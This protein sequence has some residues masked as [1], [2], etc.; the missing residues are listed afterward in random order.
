M[1]AAIAHELNQPLTATISFARACQA[2]LDGPSRDP[3]TDRE[4]RGL[5]DQA[6]AQALRAGEIIRRTREFLKHGDIRLG[7]VELP[8]II[9]SAA[10]LMRAKAA[11][12]RV[13]LVTRLAPSLPPVLGD[14]IQIEQVLLNLIR[15]GIDALS[16]SDA[17]A[18]EV[19][20]AAAPASQAGFIEISVRDTGPGFSPEIVSRLF[21]ALATTKET[22]MGL[23]LSISRSIV[24]AHGGRIW[25]ATGGAGGAEIRLT[26]PI[27]GRGDD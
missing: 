24:E 9:E 27:Y 18:G 25:A 22:G 7:K 26:L 8:P 6:V 11:R 10:E 13:S 3:A 4:A 12:H 16:R 1:A 14:A 17:E 5:I 21:T 19:T 23:G 2:V 15:N 20:I